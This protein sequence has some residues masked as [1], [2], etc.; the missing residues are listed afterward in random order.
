M[1][2][3]GS[4]ARTLRRGL[5]HIENTA[6]PGQAGNVA[7]AGHR[8]S[9]F[10]S[11]K[12]VVLGDDV[13]LDTGRERF[14]YRVSS[15][16]VVKSDDLS[17]LSP[18]PEAMLTL[19]T[20]YPFVFVGHAPDRFIVRAT[21]DDSS[22]SAPSRSAAVVPE[23]LH[24]SAPGEHGRSRLRQPTAPG[25]TVPVDNDQLVRQTIE[26]FRVIYNARVISRDEAGQAGPLLFQTCSIRFGD[27]WST[28]TCESWSRTLATPNPS[29]WTFTLRQAG[30]R[31]AI[32]SVAAK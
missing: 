10:R 11:L 22:S 30:S 17:V 5:G 13:Y 27:D 1:V 3:H 25:S 16:R 15:F 18:T 29:V 23:P 20:C 32:V 24:R 7:I 6:G 28:A 14:H 2:L 9:F 12:D 19:V 4:D 26:R 21:R 8:D 31:W